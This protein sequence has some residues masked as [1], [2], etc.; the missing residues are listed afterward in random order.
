MYEST[1]TPSLHIRA[2]LVAPLTPNLMLSSPIPSPHLVW[3]ELDLGMPQ[4]LLGSISCHGARHAGMALDRK[5]QLG[6]QAR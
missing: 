1:P 4:H 2:P 6:E 5:A 3:V